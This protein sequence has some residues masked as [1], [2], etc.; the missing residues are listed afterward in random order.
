MGSS[1]QYYL[2]KVKSWGLLLLKSM[3][4]KPS[5]SKQNT[6]R[7]LE[8]WMLDIVQSCLA[9][10]VG[11]TTL[12][13]VSALSSSP[14][15]CFRWLWARVSSPSASCMKA[16]STSPLWLSCA[17]RLPPEVLRWHDAVQLS[18]C[19]EEND[20]F[21]SLLGNGIWILEGKQFVV[22]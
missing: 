20:T 15:I 16:D 8:I 19:A 6:P 18:V 1:I 12:W 3:R 17:V 21:S 5:K 13:Y 7:F 22:S 4:L 10:V 11:Q 2:V 14:V 9:P